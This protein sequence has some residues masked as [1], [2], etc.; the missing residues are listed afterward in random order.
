MGI[1]QRHNCIF[2]HIP[3]TAGTSIEAA[4]GMHGDLDFIGKKAYT[5]QGRNLETF[6]GAGLQHLT[7]AELKAHPDL[8]LRFEDCFRFTIVRNPWDRLISALAYD[9][10][11][12]QAQI[13]KGIDH[14]SN[15]I[16][17]IHQD[18]QRGELFRKKR[19][20]P[21]TRYFQDKSGRS[22]VDF[23][24]RFENLATDWKA[25]QGRLGESVALEHR[26][27]SNRAHYS[28]QYTDETRDMVAE[29]Y[30]EDITAL[31]YS[32]ETTG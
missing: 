29:I 6:F 13:A 2:V 24:G 19:F 23:I 26:M 21:Q 27:R 7:A 25:L 32:F 4:L 3:K 1:S 5:G 12:D 16:R 15:R 18:F 20:L 17:M 30:A 11:F 28:A 9:G 22:L 31:G 8:P 10:G 14:Y